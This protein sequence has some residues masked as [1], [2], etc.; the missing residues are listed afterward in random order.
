MK[1]Y[2]GDVIMEWYLIFFSVLFLIISLL[3]GMY[4]AFAM[5]M[6][7]MMI[8]FFA[9]GISAL[10]DI[11]GYSCWNSALSFVLVSI[12]LFLLMGNI[13]VAT[14]VGEMSYNS[15]TPWLHF[16]PGRL[17]VTNIVACAVFAAISG[18][19]PA[20][21]AAIGNVA[22]PLQRSKGYKEK[23]ICGSLAGGATIGIL[24]PPSIAFI[25][26]GSMTDQSVG[27]LFIAGVIPGIIL[28]VLF[29]LYIVIYSL[30]KEDMAPIST[31]TYSWRDRFSVLKNIVPVI[32]LLLG[33]MGSI[34]TG[35]A[36]P[37]EA[38]AIGVLGSL[39]I[40]L[41]LRKMSVKAFKK[42][43][44]DAVY[45]SSW[46]LFLLIGSSILSYGI[47]LAGFP[48]YIGKV[49]SESGLSYTSIIIML[50]FMYIALGC[51]IDP[52][53]MM[54]M[55]LP[56]VYPIL[57]MIEADLIWFG[58][59]MVLLMETGLITP[60]VGM[61]LFVMMGVSGTEIGEITMG[62][63]PYVFI[64]LLMIGIIFIFPLLAT[65]LPSQML[66]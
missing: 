55:T 22:V 43:V 52:I 2:D 37:T 25:L 24:I 13:I 59:I 48:Q 35:V 51:I 66:F 30:I 9:G 56:V 57:V 47:S 3:S 33:I 31:E 44:L 61:N 63:L 19:S 49:I 45:A 54:F 26:Y 34:Y 11:I 41:A 12:P 17:L 1:N 29:I 39:I 14:G 53:S 60:P 32:I 6:V 65:W 21:A 10:G 5:A 8:T 64:L 15:I 18:S 20:T 42:A 58:V 27:K 23:Y 38:A 7:G 40:G 16:F 28:T 36:T 62:T 4:I 46:L 50:L